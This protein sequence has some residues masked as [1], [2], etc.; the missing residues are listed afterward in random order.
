MRK[1]VLAVV[2]AMLAQPVPAEGQTSLS[3]IAQSYSAKQLGQLDGWLPNLKTDAEVD[4]PTANQMAEMIFVVTTGCKEKLGWS[5]D[6]LQ[7]AF[8]FEF[9]RLMELAFT[10]HGP[11][12]DEE[13]ARLEATLAKG[14]RTA[15]W[16]ALEGDVISG[17]TGQTAI[18]SPS[19]D[20]L[21]VQLMLEAGFGVDKTKAEQIGIFLGTKAMQRFSQ[22]VFSAQK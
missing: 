10:Q 21:Y 1:M 8:L 22:R 9:G 15:L 4:D 20:A 7:P 6:Q 14:D 16:A 17:M 12:A 19:S 18:T 3:C 2:A 13:I 5:D 11:L